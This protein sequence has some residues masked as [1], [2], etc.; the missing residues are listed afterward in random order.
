LQV[1]FKIIFKKRQPRQALSEYTLKNVNTGLKQIINHNNTN[2]TNNNQTYNIKL[3]A[4]GKEN[5]ELIRNGEIFNIM[6]K[7]FNSVPELIKA[8]HFNEERPENH[9]QKLVF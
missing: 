1:L 9:K 4:Y 2:I 6:K 7:G 8:I 3:V 5:K